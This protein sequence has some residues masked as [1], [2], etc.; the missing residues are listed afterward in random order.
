MTQNENR[1]DQVGTTLRHAFP[2]VR[3]GTFY[4]MLA[5]LRD[6][7]SALKEDRLRQIYGAPETGRQA[8]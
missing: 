8:A 1:V 7:E 5:V 4:S 3:D 2:A 6:A